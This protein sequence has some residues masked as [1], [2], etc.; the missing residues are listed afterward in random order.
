MET[1]RLRNHAYCMSTKTK[2]ARCPG[3][4]NIKFVFSVLLLRGFPCFISF[5]RSSLWSSTKMIIW[6]S[7]KHYLRENSSIPVAK[8]VISSTDSQ[9]RPMIFPKLTENELW[10]VKTHLI[11]SSLTPKPESPLLKFTIHVG[12]FGI[13]CSFRSIPVLE[14]LILP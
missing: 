1:F 14:K 4:S 3:P 5:S 10:I 8:F 11:G 9:V 7:N 12:P 2:I 6:Q 13:V